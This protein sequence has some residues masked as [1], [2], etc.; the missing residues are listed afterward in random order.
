MIG[1]L[2]GSAMACKYTGLVS[3]VVPSFVLLVVAF[4]Q[5]PNEP[6]RRL[7]HAGAVFAVGVAIMIGPWLLRNLCDTGNPVYPLGYSVFGGIDWN[8]ELNERWRAAH[9]PTEHNLSMILTKHFPDVTLDNTWTSGILFALAIPSV[10]LWRR[11]R[12][13]LMLGCCRF[14]GSPPGGHSRIVSIDS[15]FQ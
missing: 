3:V 8:A 5:N 4:W 7:L 14:G 6:S 11:D 9:G 13:V 1:L 10:V 2:A 12:R 15:G